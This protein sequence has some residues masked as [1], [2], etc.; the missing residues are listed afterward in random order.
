VLS[1]TGKRLGSRGMYIRYMNGANWSA[2]SITLTLDLKANDIIT[3]VIEK[4]GN[5][6]DDQVSIMADNSWLELKENIA[7]IITQDGGGSGGGARIN[8][9]EYNVNVEGGSSN[10]S[11]NTD[12]EYV[13]SIPGAQVGDGV[14][15]NVGPVIYSKLH[16]ATT[17]L[18]TIS[19]VSA[20]DTVKII[21]RVG[22]YITLDN[23]ATLNITTIGV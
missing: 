8:T 2:D 20:P 15:V 11:G 1:T 17:G 5:P 21:C 12:Y 13:I 18:D 6:D 14:V 16:T 4:G 3:V 10:W 22:A 23:T 19:F 9:K 7:S